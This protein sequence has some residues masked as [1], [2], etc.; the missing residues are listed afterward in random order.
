V[1]P[2]LTLVT[3]GVRDVAASRR[4]YVEGL[5]WRPTLD[6]PEVVFVQVGHG[7]LLALFAA[8]ALEADVGSGAAPGD[9]ATA[10][11]TLAHNVGSEQEVDTAMARAA[12]AGARVLKPAR[13][14]EW[15]GYHGYVADPDGFRWE[16]AHNPGLVVDADGAVRFTEA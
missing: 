8:D 15:G 12:A 9:A 4:F 6:L 7:L 1:D 2:H 11:V 5:G 14:A 16:I 13:R 10:P 3:L